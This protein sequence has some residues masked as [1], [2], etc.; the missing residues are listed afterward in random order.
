MSRMSKTDR[1]ENNFG[2]TANKSKG[3]LER[4]LSQTM[5]NKKLNRNASNNSQ[6]I[7]SAHHDSQDQTVTAFN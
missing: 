4:S 3:Q 2:L 5:S 6:I 1:E 7:I